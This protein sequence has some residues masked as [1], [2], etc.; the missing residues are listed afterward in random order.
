MFRN[1]LFDDEFLREHYDVDSLDI[2]EEM[3]PYEL[4]HA[5]LTDIRRLENLVIQTRE[6]VNRLSSGAL[7]YDM[8]AQDVSDGS[9]YDSPALRRYIELY[10]QWA[11]IPWEC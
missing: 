11:V 7:A 10:A 3:I 8:T 1:S 5:L 2:M 9:Y 4:I 6:E